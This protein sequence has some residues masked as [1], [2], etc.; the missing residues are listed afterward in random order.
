MSA[1]RTDREMAVVA[2]ERLGSLSALANGGGASPDQCET[3]CAEIREALRRL[4]NH[5]EARA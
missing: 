1:Q 2:L 5:D 4:V 3:L